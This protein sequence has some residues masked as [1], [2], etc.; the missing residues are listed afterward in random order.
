[1]DSFLVEYERLM[2]S[3][4]RD[5]E[6]ELDLELSTRG[7]SCEDREGPLAAEEDMMLGSKLRWYE[8]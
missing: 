3:E 8:R 2:L 7:L 6:L 1:M 4:G 5:S